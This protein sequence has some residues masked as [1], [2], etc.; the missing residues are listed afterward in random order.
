M[1]SACML[2]SLFLS[3]WYFISVSTVCIPSNKRIHI[4]Y[5]VDTLFYTLI[6]AIYLPLFCCNYNCFTVKALNRMKTSHQLSRTEYIDA[7]NKY[8]KTIE[9][10]YEVGEV[11]GKG[12]YATGTYTT[13][14]VCCVVPTHMTVIR[15]CF[16]CLPAV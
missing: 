5:S 16:Y 12:G 1:Y 6:V 9:A 8:P 13:Y 2:Q 7:I 10:R 15:H 4:S 14:D 3:L 11:L